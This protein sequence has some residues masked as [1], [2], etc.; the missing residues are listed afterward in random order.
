MGSTEPDLDAQAGR[1]VARLLQRAHLVGP[2]EIA[3][4]VAAAARPLG[5]TGARIYLADLQQ[6]NLRP[7][8]AGPDGPQAL[9]VD[10]TLAG[11][12]YRTVTIC[13]AAAAG[14]AGGAGWQAWLPLIG[15]TERLGVLE[16]D[17]AEVSEPM[18][19]RYRTIASLT[20]LVV[21]SKTMFSDTLAAGRR[22]GKMA[23]Q[24]ELVWGFLVPRTFGTERVLVAAMLEPAYQVGG[25]AFDYALTGDQLQVSIFDGV[26]H[27]LDAGLIAS[28]GLASCRR[29]RRAGGTLAEM[30][31]Q[32]DDAIARH[33]GGS[34]F[35]TALVGEL[36]VATGEFSWIPCG[37]PPP[38]L[39]R[40]SKVI[41]ELARRPRLPLG[42]GSLETIS[43]SRERTEDAAWLYTERLQ[44]GD[45]LLLYTDGITEGRS[46]DGTPFGV[47]R[48][49][50]FVIR[51]SNA[52][53][54][55]H[56]TLRRLN[57][58][59]VEYQNERLIDDA[60][61]VLVEWMPDRPERLLISF[62]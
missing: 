26:G 28:V 15:G 49:S 55:A 38:L 51:H 33:F 25:D 22:T 62:G 19:A 11:L 60:T 9:A 29:T 1:V 46:A 48:L 36:D 58:A 13:Y 50:D 21:A 41:K 44:P 4:C 34:R 5:V 31:G 12:A 18:L 35:L 24:A 23:L 6:R 43:G 56:E 47:E 53:I 40:D 37:H 57:H 20:G 14:G 8:P 3:A 45:R 42:L 17:C 10:G 2:E 7:V 54:S 16:L 30:V 39:I 61:I 32:A 27:D 59:I 52:G